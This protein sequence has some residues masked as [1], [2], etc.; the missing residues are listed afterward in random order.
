MRLVPGCENHGTTGA[1]R[2]GAA[3][4]LVAAALFLAMAQAA[5]SRRAPQ[6]PAP[7]SGSAP[8][9]RPRL[10]LRIGHTWNVEA[11]AFSPNGNTLASAGGD[12]DRTVKLWDVATGTVQW[13]LADHTGS[14]E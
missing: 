4:L 14:V 5:P 6:P 3:A 7:A 1:A 13:T 2:A 12:R 10:D 11:V 8:A 9:L